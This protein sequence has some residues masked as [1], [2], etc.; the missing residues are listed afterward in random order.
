MLMGTRG[1]PI[2]IGGVYGYD[3]PV[4]ATLNARSEEAAS[5]RSR[6]AQLRMWSAPPQKGLLEV[7][8]RPVAP[9]LCGT[10]ESVPLVLGGSR[11]L[12]EQM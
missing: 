4:P 9:L 6:P 10:H 12:P 7:C 11:R 1:T 5:A 3:Y 8:F 2:R